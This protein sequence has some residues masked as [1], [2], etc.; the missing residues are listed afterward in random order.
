MTHFSPN[1]VKFDS[2]LGILVVKPFNFFS[3]F[4]QKLKKK[5]F[6]A[7]NFITFFLKWV[8]CWLVY[9]KP[10]LWSQK[11]DVLAFYWKIQKSPFLAKSGSFFLKISVIY[12][13]FFIKSIYLPYYV[14]ICPN[15]VFHVISRYS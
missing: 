13:L 8:T 10:S 7:K 6:Q 3:S 9:T 1:W 14:L 5:L 11:N 4:L 15:S 2:N 12:C